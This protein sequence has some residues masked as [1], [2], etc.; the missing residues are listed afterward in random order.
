MEKYISCD[1]HSAHFY[2]FLSA[3]VAL[4]FSPPPS[5]FAYVQCY[6][7]KK[8]LRGI[9]TDQSAAHVRQTLLLLQILTKNKYLYITDTESD[10]HIN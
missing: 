4:L 3:V 10:L 2:S 5:L 8:K 7:E 9:Y 1:T 6:T